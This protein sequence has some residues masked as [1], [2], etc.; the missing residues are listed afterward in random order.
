MAARCAT[1]RHRPAASGGPSLATGPLHPPADRGSHHDFLSPAPCSCCR[2]LRMQSR[3]SSSCRS[4][5]RLEA[6][7]SH[8]IDAHWATARIWAARALCLCGHGC[9]SWGKRGD[10]WAAVS[11][12]VG[13]V[14]PRRSECFSRGR[15]G[16]GGGGGGATATSIFRQ[17]RLQGMGRRRAQQGCRPSYRLA[18]RVKPP[19]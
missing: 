15:G 7:A 4:C 3:K 10:H 8:A 5:G 6:R 2:L 11:V 9:W 16:G 13:E 18:Q 17:R 14:K 1:A 12:G 19:V